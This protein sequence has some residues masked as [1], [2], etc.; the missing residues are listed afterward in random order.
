MRQKVS[1]LIVYAMI[2]CCSCSE[3]PLWYTFSLLAER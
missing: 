3:L 1:M 2:G